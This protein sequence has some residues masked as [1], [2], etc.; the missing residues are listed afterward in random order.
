MHLRLLKTFL[1][2]VRSGNV[3]RA[4]EQ[5]HL[6]QSSVSDQIQML[7]TEVGAELFTRTRQ[8]LVLTQAGE[9]LEPYA[10]EIL[11]L[12]D[13][14]YVAVETAAGRSGRNLTIGALE[15]IGAARLPQWLGVFQHR[16][17]DAQVKL[18]IAGSGTLLRDL[19]QGTLD[20]VFCFDKGLVDERFA[21]RALLTEPLV[22]VAPPGEAGRAT[23]TDLESMAARRFITTESGCIYRHMFD[24]AFAR[25]GM[26]SPTIAAEVGSIT[27]IG[28]LV[29]CGVGSALVPRLVVEDMLDQG[30]IVELPW[31]TTDSTV[32]LVL[33]WR[34]RRVLS[35]LLKRFLAAMDELPVSVKRA[36][37]RP[38]HAGPSPS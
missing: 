3:T 5:V 12:V 20:A 30:E 27:A 23:A 22:L 19:E 11:A 33:M 4:A 34:R 28:R 26:R 17:P 36:D 8:G 29:A 13:E 24:Q 7:E 6:A 18:K 38:Q 14:A 32:S 10:E 9:A 25:S 37:A 2:V 1:A 15:T 21:K 16:Q 31:R 35:P